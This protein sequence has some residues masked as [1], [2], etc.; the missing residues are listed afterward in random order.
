VHADAE[1]DAL[2][3][4]LNARAFTTGTDIFFREGAHNPGSSGGRELLAHELTHVVQ[5]TGDEVHRKL[6]IGRPGDRYEQEADQTSRAI[7][8][9]EQQFAQRDSQ[10]GGVVRRQAEE[11]EEEPIQARSEES[12][13]RRQAE[14][15]EEEP[16]QAKEQNV[17]VRRQEEVPEEE[18]A[19]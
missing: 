11:E 17:L 9:Q 6:S 2:N 13:I 18:E 19:V 10:E 14:E 4:S 16:L 12:S 8:E 15:E 3:R 5:Q 7:M 1:A